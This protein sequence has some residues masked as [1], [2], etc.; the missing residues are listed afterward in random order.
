MNKKAICL[1]IL[2]ITTISPCVFAG[3]VT[4]VTHGYASETSM[5]WVNDFSN[6]LIN[7]IGDNTNVALYEL[8]LLEAGPTIACTN[9]VIFGSPANTIGSA[10]VM[11]NW[12]GYSTRIFSGSDTISTFEIAEWVVDYLL[13]HSDT[14]R[15]LL[16]Q[17]LHLIGHSRGGS[18]IGAMAERLGYHGYWIDQLTF[19]DPHPTENSTG[20]DD[21]GE[22][23]MTVPGNVIFA[24]NYYRTGLGRP[25]GEVVTD[26]YTIELNN[27]YFGSVGYSGII[28]Q[29]SDVHAWYRGT[30]PSGDPPYDVESAETFQITS[31]WYDANAYEDGISRDRN[32]I[33][34][35]YSLIANNGTNRPSSGLHSGI[36][37][38]GVSRSFSTVFPYPIDNVGYLSLSSTHVTTGNTIIA[39]Y[40]YES[41]SATFGV[42]FFLDTN[43]NPYDGYGSSLGAV[44]HGISTGMD[45]ANA[46]ATLT[47]P[48]SQDGGVYSVLLKSTGSDQTRYF[49]APTQL[50]VTP[51]GP[52]NPNING[53]GKVNF[54]DFAMLAKKWSEDCN[55]W[56]NWCS[57]ADIDH[58]GL[59]DF[60]D[61]LIMTE[62]WLEDIVVEPDG[63]VWVYINDPGVSGHEGFDGWMSKYETTN[64]Q[65]CQFLNAA[66]AS[67]DITVGVDNNVYGANGSN[68]GEDFVGEFYSNTYASS[69]YSQISYSNGTFSVRSRDGFDMSNHPVVRVN[70][71][72]ATAFCN[73][74][75][76]RLPTE[77]EWQAVA[78]YDGSYT[79]ACGTTINQDKANYSN[80][81][82]L[83]LTSSPHTSPA[84]YYSAYGYGMCDMAGNVLEWT[85]S[86]NG[87]KHIIRS[88]VW[89]L[90]ASYC[91][92]S[93]SFE[94]YPS[95]ISNGYLG[96]RACRDAQPNEPEDIVWVSINDS[97][98]G[99]KDYNGDPIS[100]GGF[101]GEM[102][103]YETTNAQY[104]QFLN[105]ALASGDITVG[106]DNIVYGAEGTNSGADFVGEVYFKT[107]A[108]SSYSQIIYSGGLFSVRSR[109]GYDMSD[110]PIVMVSWY[111]A[112][113]FCNYYGYRLPTEW[114]WQAVADFDGSYTYGCGTMIDFTRANYL[115]ENGFVY[116]N[117]FSLSSEPYTS[118]VNHYSPYGYGMCDMA[119]NAVEWTSTLSYS[120]Y[121]LRGGGW[122]SFGNNCTVSYW[123]GGFPNYTSFY[124]GFRVCR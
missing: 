61:L 24:D 38:T 22:A 78:D 62:Y 34:Y 103:K 86:V 26:S 92:V 49:Y 25:D 17:P 2:L 53:E 55:E 10:V 96:F 12:T 30:I 47:I 23:G 90:N 95:N 109:D 69:T 44:S 46:P 39:D 104:C 9:G 66:L 116:A 120:A 51:L 42:E 89:D 124:V 88:G 70:W 73:Y 107:Y 3:G 108:A 20:D 119:G 99:M 58:S 67:G 50:T 64:A 18:M 77:W 56:N 85:N 16:A 54:L 11:V 8:T 29:H 102:G 101:N 14:T 79:Y 59:V 28:D 123:G 82:P 106:V 115:D 5:D 94:A 75:G 98:A 19:L 76:Y 93:Y 40:R 121:R 65:Y 83:E 100:H 118:P 68:S 7:R 84:G 91:T 52:L 31:E 36:N 80:A 27:S 81:N 72:G 87:D 45:G 113:A 43:R 60:N 21:W 57:N 71:Y 48:V 15:D 111:G 110:H 35:A 4:F 114:E 97:G 117:P 13:I 33:G 6:K 41:W 1:T 74:Y 37:G 112:T 63:M 105:T 122:D 32:S